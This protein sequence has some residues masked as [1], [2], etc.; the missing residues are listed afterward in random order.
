ME[1]ESIVFSRINQIGIKTFGDKISQYIGKDLSSLEHL[2]PELSNNIELVMNSGTV[3]SDKFT[4]R[5]NGSQEEKTFFADYIKAN[6]TT[7]LLIT[8]DFT[9]LESM[10]KELEEQEEFSYQQ[11]A[12]Y[13]PLGIINLNTEGKVIFANPTSTQLFGWINE[14][15]TLVEGQNVFDFP[16]IS[17]QQNIVQG[18]NEL[19]KGDPLVG[20]EFP[21]T[22]KNQLKFLKAYGSPRYSS[23]GS[24]A[25]AILMYTDITDLKITEEKLKR[26]KEELSDFAHQMSHDLGNSIMGI[27][28][29]AEFMAKY[30]DYS[31]LEEVIKHANKMTKILRQSLELADS[32]LLIDKKNDVDLNLLIDEVAELTIPE[33]VTFSYA[34]LPVVRGDK[35]KLIQVFE[36]M[37]RNA[38]I[39]GEPKEITLKSKIS[40][41][42]ETRGRIISISND[43]K[44]IAQ[45]H[46]EK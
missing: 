3:V 33:T 37:F 32:G 26:Q 38:I 9:E 17:E 40:I 12:E 28:G 42:A 10:E 19:L 39:H 6:N 1:S 43:G 2:F 5:A 25:G 45:K 34:K 15:I 24:L 11:L 36:N 4:V 41:E 44:P 31:Y 21:I 7:V 16:F 23:N 13:S 14:Q 20:V 35:T 27:L 22:I 46:R 30:N 8:K 29:Y 18:I